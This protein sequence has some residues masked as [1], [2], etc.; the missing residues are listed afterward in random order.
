[1]RSWIGFEN[2]DRNE[3][4][5]YSSEAKQENIFPLF[6][7]HCTFPTITLA[8]I[9]GIFLE[10][11]KFWCLMDI[12]VIQ[13]CISLRSWFFALSD[14]KP[15]CT[16]TSLVNQAKQIEFEAINTCCNVL[17]NMLATKKYLQRISSINCTDKDET[18][19]MNY[20]FCPGLIINIRLDFILTAALLAP[21]LVSFLICQHWV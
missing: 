17:G 3:I 18:N 12:W 2:E 19:E 21:S 20:S 4:S 16:V 13:T 14:T 11:S 8:K 5:Q 10:R 6:H 7:F 15:Q 9:V 1:M